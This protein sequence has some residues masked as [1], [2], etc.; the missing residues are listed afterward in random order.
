M[1]PAISTPINLNECFAFTVFF[2]KGLHLVGDRE[3]KSKKPV[4]RGELKFRLAISILILT[5]RLGRNEILFYLR[6]AK[7]QSLSRL[8]SLMCLNAFMQIP[9]SKI[10]NRGIFKR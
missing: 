8:I 1:K 2:A 6:L 4:F 5:Q 7:H 3:K 9:L 10:D